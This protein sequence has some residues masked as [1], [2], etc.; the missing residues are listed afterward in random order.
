MLES[1]QL[2]YRRSSV[3]I[4]QKKLISRYMS[5]IIRGVWM[6]ETFLGNVLATP[7][8]RAGA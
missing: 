3:K 4:V 2:K 7:R 6:Y 5:P 1:S 8:C